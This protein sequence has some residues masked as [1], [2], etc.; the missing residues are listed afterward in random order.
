MS[1]KRRLLNL[2]ISRQERRPWSSLTRLL[3]RSCCQERLVLK[4]SIVKT[5]HR[6][7]TSLA[8]AELVP[9]DDGVVRHICIGCIAIQKTLI[10]T[11]QN[12]FKF[13]FKR[14]RW[15][16]TSY[17][18]IQRI[19]KLWTLEINWKQSDVCSTQRQAKRMGIPTIIILHPDPPLPPHPGT[20][21]TLVG[22][23]HQ[24][25]SSLSTQYVGD[26][27]VFCFCPEK[28]GALVGDSF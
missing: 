13:S 15:G 12:F 27:H 17:D 26:S 20:C 10:H 18:R 4:L 1:Q 9:G 8:F 16:R 2:P 11:K 19:I 22:L 24:I 3:C 7:P 14:C 6:G 23:Y 28:S 21:G 5:K 25:S